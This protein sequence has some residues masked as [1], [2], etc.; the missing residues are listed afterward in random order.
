MDGL[1]QDARAIRTTKDEVRD[2]TNWRRSVSAL[3]GAARR[4]IIL[5]IIY[6]NIIIKLKLLP[7]LARC[8]WFR[9]LHDNSLKAG[10]NLKHQ[11]HMGEHPSTP[12]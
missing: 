3:V 1:Y 12:I 10:L 4:R 5:H 6:S 8:S 9:C 11:A 2:R 7:T